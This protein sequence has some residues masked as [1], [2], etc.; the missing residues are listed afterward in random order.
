[1]RIEILVDG[2]EEPQ[3]YPID[4]PKLSIGSGETCDVVISSDNISRKHLM[5]IAENDAY[6]V[7]DQGSTNGSFI[8]EERLVPGRRTEFTSFFPVRLGDQVLITLLSDEDMSAQ[9]DE[10]I[11]PLY[12]KD[13]PSALPGRGNAESTKMISLADLRKASTSDLQAK[14]K[15]VIKKKDTVQ[16]KSPSKKSKRAKENSNFKTLLFLVVVVVGGVGYWNF[17]NVSEDVDRPVAKMGDVVV[18]KKVPRAE[19]IVPVDTNLIPETELLPK[20]RYPQLLTDLKCVAD[21]E[22]YFCEK[23]PGANDGKHGAVQIG[24]TMHIMLDGTQVLNE[25]KAFVVPPQPD[26]TGVISPER[27]EQFRQTVNEA[28]VVM[29]L[30][31]YF[32]GDFDWEKVK[33]LKLSIGLF[34]MVDGQSSIRVVVA[35][36]PER[37]KAFKAVVSMENISNV[38][39][40]GPSAL[41]FT[42]EYYRTY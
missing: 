41:A 28:A 7:V 37:L 1:M 36:Y 15:E 22:K 2:S 24:T 27:N 20:D 31:K 29:F 21:L 34:E 23:F 26:E 16:K 12:P 5:I 8:N 14:R 6:F 19:V 3:I 17:K 30:M 18:L 11:V 33:E 42:K 25:V 40:I 35:A 38:K 13:P 4:K 9:N 32:P 10:P 39:H